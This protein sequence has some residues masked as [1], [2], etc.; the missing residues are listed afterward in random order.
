MFV[1]VTAKEGNSLIC[2]GPFTSQDVAERYA[3]YHKLWGC[4]LIV[5]LNDSGDAMD[6]DQLPR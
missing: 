4:C 2:Y 1:I 6:A 5:I 3:K